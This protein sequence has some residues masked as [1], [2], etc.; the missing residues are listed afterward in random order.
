MSQ[1]GGPDQEIEITDDRASGAKSSAL[2]SKD[3]RGLDIEAEDR[4]AAE[5]VLRS[6]SFPLGSVE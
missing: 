5:E 1:G 6:R 3:L 4:D 2:P